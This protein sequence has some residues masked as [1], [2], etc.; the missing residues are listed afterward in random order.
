MENTLEENGLR[1]FFSMFGE[2]SLKENG[3]RENCIKENG[4]KRKR[5]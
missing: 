5:A 2:N 4:Y 3:L 1:C